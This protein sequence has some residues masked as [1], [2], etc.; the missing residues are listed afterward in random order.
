MRASG[1]QVRLDY[2]RLFADVKLLGEK[3]DKT[4]LD[5]DV[6]V[7]SPLNKEYI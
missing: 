7:R 3:L 6:G 1:Y 2:L 5:S 4:N